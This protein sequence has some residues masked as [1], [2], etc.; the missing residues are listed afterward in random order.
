[1][2]EKRT[3]IHKSYLKF[4]NDKKQSLK[5][6]YVKMIFSSMDAISWA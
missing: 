3:M 4:V 2:T 6:K 1:M 5:E